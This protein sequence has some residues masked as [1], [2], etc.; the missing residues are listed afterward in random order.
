MA[1]VCKVNNGKEYSATE[2]EGSQAGQR[3]TSLPFG[4]LRFAVSLPCLVSV[5]VRLSLAPRSGATCIKDKR[6]HHRHNPN[7]VIF[8]IVKKMDGRSQS[9]GGKTE[10]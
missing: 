8:L 3:R 1:K 6:T 2:S 10:N 4:A 5:C 7:F 9:E